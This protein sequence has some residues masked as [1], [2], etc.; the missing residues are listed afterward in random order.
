M[1]TIPISSQKDFEAWIVDRWREKDALLEFYEQTGRFP[2]DTDT[3]ASTPATSTILLKSEDSS[4]GG[5]GDDD[6]ADSRAWGR[7][8]NTES[9][10]DY[11]E[12]DVK[13]GSVLDVLAIFG[14]L[15]CIG[16]AAYVVTLLCGTLFE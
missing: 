7:G 3:P 16:V 4:Q 14:P 13:V 11:L 2:A 9:N 10:A 1:S 15:M 12:T 6:L 8:S 5:D